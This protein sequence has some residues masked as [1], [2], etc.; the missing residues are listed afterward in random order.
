ML[1]DQ[2]RALLAGDYAKDYRVIQ[3]RLD[4]APVFA[5]AYS[6]ALT[7]SIPNTTVDTL[8]GAAWTFFKAEDWTNI[9]VEL[10]MHGFYN[11]AG[12]TGICVYRVYVDGTNKGDIARHDWN[13]ASLQR[14]P[15]SGVL[16]ISG[17]RAGKHLISIYGSATTATS[18]DLS[19]SK[20]RALECIPHPTP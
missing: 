4:R 19:T 20:A 14:H 1:P 5:P 3:E 2:S 11:S 9:E 6:G 7:A 17:I 15:V 18:A 10:W 12:T 16:S 13:I 8:L